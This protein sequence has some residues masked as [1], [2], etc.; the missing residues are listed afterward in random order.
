MAHNPLVVKAIGTFGSEAKLAAAA[1]V[2]QPAIHKAK[3]AKRVSAELAQKIETATGGL[4]PRHEL[5][6]DLWAAPTSKQDT[7]A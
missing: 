1:G 3:R 2:T 7:A 5:R 4:V 6:P